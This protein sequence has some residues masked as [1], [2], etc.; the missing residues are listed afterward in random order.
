MFKPSF[1]QTTNRPSARGGRPAFT[2]IELLVV[3]AIIAILAGLLLPALAKAKGKAGTIR[4][5]NNLKQLTLAWF[6]YPN[7]NNDVLVKNWVVHP[8]AWI[9]GLPDQGDVDFGLR[10]M[11]NR[12]GI[13]KGLLYP[14]NTSVEIYRCPNE[15]AVKFNRTTGPTVVRVRNY[16]MNGQMGGADSADIRMGAID[17]SWVQDPQAA[18]NPPRKKYADIKRPSPSKAMVFVHEHANTIEDGY[19][20]VKG[21][22][23]IWQNPPSSLHGNAGTVSFADGHSEVWKWLESETAKRS[24][25]DTPSKKPVDRD[26]IRFQKATAT[27]EDE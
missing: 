21:F 13:E 23:N 18:K 22:Q 26:L 5:V 20:A 8:Q 16:S 27:L 25:R 10:G 7:D 24:T 2:L 6:M 4:C 11:T 14:Y 12:A 3:I 17:T 9:N 1:H 19:F 15:P